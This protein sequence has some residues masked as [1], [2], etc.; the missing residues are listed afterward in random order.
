MKKVVGIAVGFLVLGL[1]ATAQG[2]DCPGTSWRSSGGRSCR[3]LGLDSQRG[4]CLPGD[5]YETLCDDMKDMIKTCYGPRRCQEEA[6]RD[7]H[8]E[9]DDRRPCDWD[10]NYN[11]P[12]PSGYIN[13]D[14]E[15]ACERDRGW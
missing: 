14:C 15:G 2:E 1:V 6:H 8:H 3:D 9:R 10:Y 4:T 7:R 5:M 13:L 11:Q 12:C